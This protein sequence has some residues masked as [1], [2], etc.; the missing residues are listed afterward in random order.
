MEDTSHE[1]RS[2]HILREEGI[3]LMKKYEGEFPKKYFKEFLE[4]LDIKE[5][6]FWKIVDSW[7]D[8]RLWSKSSQ[9]KWKFK[10]PIK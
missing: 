9:G 5:N 3:A 7:R 10:Y 2:G 8:P 1:I 4:F 6:D